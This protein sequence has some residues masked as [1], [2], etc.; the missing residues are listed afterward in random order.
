MNFNK[1]IKISISFAAV[2]LPLVLLSGI[3]RSSEK[4]NQENNPPQT[5]QSNK[6]FKLVVIDPG[7]GGNLPGAK[8]RISVEKDITLQ[9][10]K[11]LK[12]A[13]EKE[14]PGVKANAKDGR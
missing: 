6:T 7:H 1:S 2:L 4:K 8:G 11:R 9:V 12:E 10:G 14:M 5:S 3:V 13:I